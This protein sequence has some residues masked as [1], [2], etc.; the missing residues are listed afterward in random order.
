MEIVNHVHLVVV[1][2]FVRNCR[3]VDAGGNGSFPNC[4]FEPDDA[5][6]E[7]GTDAYIIGEPPLELTQAETGVAGKIQNSEQSDGTRTRPVS[8]LVFGIQQTGSA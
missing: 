5:G 2:K 8:R 7:L 6:I 4:G 1:P 3:P